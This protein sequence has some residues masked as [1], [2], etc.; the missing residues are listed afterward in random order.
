MNKRLFLPSI[1]VLIIFNFLH[2]L[3]GGVEIKFKKQVPC[4]DGIRQVHAPTLVETNPGC[5]RIAWFGG[6]G[7]GK[8][9]V[10]IWSSEYDNKHEVFSTPQ[11]LAQSQEI[12]NKDLLSG[13]ALEKKDT[14]CWN[15]VFCKTKNSL[16]LFYKIGDKPVSWTGF[17]KESFDGGKT[18]TTQQ[19]LPPGIIGPTKNK[20]LV[21]N[22]GTIICGS[23]RES[24]Q[25]WGCSIEK[26]KKVGQLWRW[27]Q[28]GP[29][30]YKDQFFGVIQPAFF[31]TTNNDLRMLVR[32]KNIGFLCSATSQDNGTT[33]SE[34]AKTG[35]QSNDSGIDIET[36]IDGRVVL[37]YNNL[38]QGKRHKLHVAIS[39]DAGN[40]WNDILT[41][42]ESPD[43]KCQICYPSIIQASDGLIYIVYTYNREHIQFVALDINS[44]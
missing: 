28:Q 32:S 12:E 4:V 25:S 42:D 36:L 35:I 6:S 43:E 15:P 31:R 33:W 34:L 41:L 24:W 21:L 38:P 30:F 26:A 37:V 23:S 9:D 19:Q 13:K 5:F 8:P 39:S 29:I 16:L 3:H 44:Q 20:P 17:M 2:V 40:T 14:A 18:F 27:E 11:I 10:K 1:L 7:D 22:D